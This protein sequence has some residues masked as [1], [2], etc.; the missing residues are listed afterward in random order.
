[1]STDQAVAIIEKAR[2][3]HVKWITYLEEDPKNGRQEKP[4]V[5][6]AG[7]AVH[8]QRWVDGYDVVLAALRLPGADD[9]T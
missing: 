8:H 6:T 9:E 7:D 5:V 2:A 1:M 4:V 3:I